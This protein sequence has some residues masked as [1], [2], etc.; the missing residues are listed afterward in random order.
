M[1]PHGA[2]S[3]AGGVGHS[4]Y[5]AAPPGT[6]GLGTLPPPGSYG[7]IPSGYGPPKPPHMGAG[8]PPGAYGSAAAAAAGGPVSPALDMGMS[9]DP[10]SSLNQKLQGAWSAS[11]R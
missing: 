8:Y 9:L 4:G 3:G 1:Y 11:I 7:L 5:A 2:G 10:M 6:Y